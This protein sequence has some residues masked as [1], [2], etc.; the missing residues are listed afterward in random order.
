MN[1]N[2]QTQVIDAEERLRQ[3][4]LH[5]DVGA[6]D[7]LI[8]PELLF[9]NHL[10]QLVSKADDLATHRSGVFRL[11]TLTPSQQHIR[12]HSGGAVVSVLM[13]LV[14][15]FHDTPIDFSLRYTRVW[16]IAADGTLQIMAGHAS[17]LSFSPSPEG[18]GAAANT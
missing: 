1:G 16:A 17:A 4:M 6:L 8:A 5:A 3:A 10:G 12:L 9:T 13:H 14:G 2:L 15:S 18:V 11:E 7:A